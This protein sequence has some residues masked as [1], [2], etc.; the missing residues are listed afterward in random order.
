MP[1]DRSSNSAASGAAP[2]AAEGTSSSARTAS[3][4]IL[5]DDL[6]LAHVAPPEHPERGERL[7][8]V[9]EGLDR[10]LTSLGE[11][12][13]YTR[14]AA[15]DVTTEQLERVHHPA[16]VAE[17][18]QLVG[19]TGLLDSDTYVSPGS[20][21]A[22]W[23][24]AGA[25]VAL[26]DAL[27]DGSAT[28][29]FAL[30]RP[31]GHHALA[32]SAMGFCLLN[33]V[34][35]AAAHARARGRSRV[36]VLDWDVHHGNGT[37]AIFYDDPSVLFISLHQ[38][39]NYPGTGA[40]GDVG[41]GDGRGKTVN[42]PLPPGGGD[43][44]YEAAFT[45]V[46]LPIIEQFSP[47]LALVSCGFDAHA[48]DPL[49][50]MELSSAAYGKMT[51]SLLGAL[52]SR[53]PL[54]LVLEGGYDLQALAESSDAVARAL[55]DAPPLQDMPRRPTSHQEEEAL[56]QVERAQTPYWKLG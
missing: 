3:V 22:A 46:V 52:P 14:P 18:G 56:R 44:L 12:Y 42:L 15:P 37:E 6:F 54:G 50:A 9:R 26:V 20:V 31:P 7:L 38:F 40:H 51:T 28:R 13:G 39:P 8:A 27:V 34:A 36:L 32:D 29:G 1:P 55:F 5:D 16:H 45:R 35:V 53:C 21:R 23:R 25:A 24:A 43:S 49:A 19:R 17:L 30:P 33:N 4:L 41:S 48:L 11:L 2:A 10:T 47:D